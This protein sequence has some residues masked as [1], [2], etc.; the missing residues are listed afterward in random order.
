MRPGYSISRCL[1]TPLLFSAHAKLLSLATC[2]KREDESGTRER[3]FYSESRSVLKG[4]GALVCRGNANV[5]WG[6]DTLYF[7]RWRIEKAT[8]IRPRPTATCASFETAEAPF[9]KNGMNSKGGKEGGNEKERG[10]E[11]REE[12]ARLMINKRRRHSI[13][14]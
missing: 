11:E 6:G 4:G 2:I 10:R 8:N 13:R 7:G 1:S 5:R 14:H 9:S 12:S 3:Q